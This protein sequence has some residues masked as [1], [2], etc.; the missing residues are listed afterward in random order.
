MSEVK[1]KAVHNFLNHFSLGQ[2]KREKMQRKV[3][4]WIKDTL[5][6]CKNLRHY[7]RWMLWRILQ[8]FFFWFSEWYTLDLSFLEVNILPVHTSPDLLKLESTDV[9]LGGFSLVNI[10]LICSY[11]ILYSIRYCATFPC[12]FVL[13]FPHPY[14]PNE[15]ITVFTWVSRIITVS[16]FYLNLAVFKGIFI[17]LLFF[18]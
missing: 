16:G 2:L 14:L 12:R 11:L 4:L 13:S 7:L 10:S 3:F 17:F 15:L 6:N 1:S 8:F 9:H 18:R 5:K